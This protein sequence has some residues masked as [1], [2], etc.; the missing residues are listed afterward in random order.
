MCHKEEFFQDTEVIKHLC[1]R[2]QLAPTVAPTPI[3]AIDANVFI[4]LT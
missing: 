4:K 2:R 3:L 1:S